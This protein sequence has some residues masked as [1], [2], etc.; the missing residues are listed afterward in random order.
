MKSRRVLKGLQ[1][2]WLRHHWSLEYYSFPCCRAEMMKKT[3]F[4]HFP[5]NETHQNV[6]YFWT[7]WSEYLSSSKILWF[8]LRFRTPPPQNSY[9]SCTILLNLRSHDSN[10]PGGPVTKTLH[11]QWGGLG[12]IAGQGTRSHMLQLSVHMCCNLKDPTSTTKIND[13]SCHNWNP[14][15]PK[16]K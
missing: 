2:I 13:P 5:S 12:S 8:L 10:F 6:A 11:S 4:L 14:T 15:Q 16:N 7:W 1:A 3:C 9:S